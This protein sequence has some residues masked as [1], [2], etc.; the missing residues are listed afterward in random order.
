ML[1]TL[2]SIYGSKESL[3]V[4]VMCAKYRGH[5]AIARPAES[6]QENIGEFVAAAT[7]F[8]SLYYHFCLG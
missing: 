5:P 3:P 7:V 1:A 6:F 2:T 4:Q 8:Q